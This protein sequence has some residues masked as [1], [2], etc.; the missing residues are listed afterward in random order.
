MHH[1]RVKVVQALIERNLLASQ[2]RLQPINSFYNE[3]NLHS[4]CP[5]ENTVANP[6]SR[7]ASEISAIVMLYLLPNDGFASKGILLGN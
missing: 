3:S 7:Y 4:S 1:A 6:Q 2:S 5:L